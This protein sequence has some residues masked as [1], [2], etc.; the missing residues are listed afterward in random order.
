MIITLVI[1]GILLVLIIIGYNNIVK[2]KNMVE[3]SWSQI[4]VLLKQRFEMIPNLV[5]VVKGYSNYEKNILEN[6]VNA[7]NR[8]LVSTKRDDI[9]DSDNQ[10]TQA[11]SKLFV[12]TEAYPDLK[13]DKHYIKLQTSLEELENKIAFARQFYNDTILKYNLK[14][15]TVPSNIVAILFGFKKY[16]YFKVEDKERQNV[17]IN[18]K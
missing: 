14:I 17:N 11:L 10:L 6:V 8:G 4:D 15:E 18:L 7:R 9:I 12:L 3:E 5:E 1:I 13:A 2:Q 16:N